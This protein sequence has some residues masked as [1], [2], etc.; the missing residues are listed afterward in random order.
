MQKRRWDDSPY[1]LLASTT[2]GLSRD[3]RYPTFEKG[4]TQRNL[5]ADDDR[6]YTTK[7]GGVL[8]MVKKGAPKR[9]PS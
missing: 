5:L 4:W 8:R 2:G 7:P 3:D 1:F 9:S 6:M